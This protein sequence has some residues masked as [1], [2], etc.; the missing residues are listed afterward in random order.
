[1]AIRP[2]VLRGTV[3]TAKSPYG[4]M[5]NGE[6]VYGESSAHGSGHRRPDSRYQKMLVRQPLLSLSWRANLRWCQILFV[7]IF[8][9]SVQA[10]I[11]NFKAPNDNLM[12]NHCSQNVN[13]YFQT[14]NYEVTNFIYNYK[15]TTMVALLWHST[16][17]AS[18]HG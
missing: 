14:E 1:M 15:T 4:E 16:Q 9:L 3:R 7:Y 11:I 18:E 2:T 10:N 5:A 6:L 8:F 13:E 17:N 12:N